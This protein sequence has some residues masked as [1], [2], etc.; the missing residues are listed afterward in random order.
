MSDILDDS[1]FSIQFR[2][3]IVT[4]NRPKIMKFNLSLIHQRQRMM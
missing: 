3:D 1:E 2:Y 4:A